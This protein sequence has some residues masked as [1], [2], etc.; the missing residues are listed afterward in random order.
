MPT[1]DVDGASLYYRETGAGAPLLLIHGAGAH[2]DLFDGVARS[3]S[4]QRRVIVYDRRGHSRS[5]SQ[6]APVKGYLARQVAD[7]AALLRA[8]DAAPAAVFGWSVGGLIALGLALDHPELVERVVVYEP[9]LYASKHM[10]LTWAWPMLK[11]QVLSALGRE[12]SAAEVIL[13]VLMARP[14]GTNGYDRVDETIRDGVLR[15]A[16]TLLHEFKTGTGEELTRERLQ[17][18]HCPI[19]AILGSETQAIFKEATQRLLEILPHVSVRRIQGA[20]HIAVMTHP[21]EVAR[22]ALQP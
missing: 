21:A 18:L 15:N 3:C 13:R 14:D 10:P 20:D 17:R 9:P 11:V 8:L 4:E 7:A 12:R 19:T 1:V 2:A 5:G 22:L 16:S 6:P